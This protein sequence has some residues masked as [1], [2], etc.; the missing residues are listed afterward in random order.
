MWGADVKV[1]VVIPFYPGDNEEQSRQ[2]TRNL[3][4]VLRLYED[5]YPE[6]ERVIATD[7]AIPF[8]KAFANN[9]V[10]FTGKILRTSFPDVLLFN[11]ADSLCSPQAI[12]N[13]VDMAHSQPGL[14]R[15]FRHYRRLTEVYT[16]NLRYWRDAFNQ[17]YDWHMDGSLSHA[18]IAVRYSC[19]KQVGGYDPRFR[20]WGY[21]DLAADIMFGAFWQARYVNTGTVVHLHHKPT[22]GDPRFASY[23]A[24]NEQLYYK[25]YCKLQG[26]P[27]ALLALRKEAG[28]WLNQPL[29]LNV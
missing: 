24:A 11:D 10:I 28:E 12:R 1:L 25:R 18:C 7:Y 14:V 15:A 22:E 21:E 3:R 29:P 4:H 19:Y 5:C 23:Q 8:S 6:W 17:P 27:E 13:A 20:A 9:Q 26:D 16:E 2:R